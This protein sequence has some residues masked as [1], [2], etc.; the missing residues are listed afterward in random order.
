MRVVQTLIWYWYYL[1]RNMLQEESCPFSILKSQV[2]SKSG[3]S[4]L[5]ECPYGANSIFYV[6]IPG[7]V[8]SANY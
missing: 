2:D 4:L 7:K 8:H 6:S 3:D 1:N 5:P